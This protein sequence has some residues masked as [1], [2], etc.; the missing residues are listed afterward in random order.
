MKAQLI[1]SIIDKIDKIFEKRSIIPV[2]DYIL[3]KDNKIHYTN[4]C[5]SIVCDFPYPFPGI[6]VSFRSLKEYFRTVKPNDE[7]TLSDGFIV[8]AGSSLMKFDTCD[9]DDYP[10]IPVFDCAEHMGTIYQK[11]I[12]N[13]A[14]CLLFTLND[15]FK[16]NLGNVFIDENNIVS[17]DGSVLLFFKSKKEIVGKY[18][19]SKNVVNTIKPFDKVE[20]YVL[21]DNRFFKF[22]GTILSDKKE[23]YKFP[24]WKFIEDLECFAEVVLSKITFKN[25][26]QKLK[27]ISQQIVFDYNFTNNKLTLSSQDLNTGKECK[28]DIPFTVKHIDYLEKTFKCVFSANYLNTYMRINN[29]VNTVHRLNMNKTY[30][31]ELIQKE[32]IKEEEVTLKNGKKKIKKVKVLTPFNEFVLDEDGNKIVKE[33]NYKVPSTFDNRFFICQMLIN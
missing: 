13:M 15:D 1:K 32:V 8:K 19:I 21:E 5:Q 6:L 22:N 11:D 7:I 28:V 25:A 29:N 4:L 3:V 10:K 16:P 26:I 27:T 9:I 31:T 23:D 18:F 12:H 24:D 17:T 30:K 2:M 33:I 14:D 20:L